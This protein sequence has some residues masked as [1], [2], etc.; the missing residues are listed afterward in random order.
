M[1]NIILLFIKIHNVEKLKSKRNL[2]GLSKMILVFFIPQS[3]EEHKQTISK[4]AAYQTIS[5]FFV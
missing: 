2:S 1:Q 3:H 5:S 4:K